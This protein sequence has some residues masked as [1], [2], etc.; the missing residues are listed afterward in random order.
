M[1]ASVFVVRYEVAGIRTQWAIKEFPRQFSF[2]RREELSS[3][4]EPASLSADDAA[5]S[6][7]TTTARVEERKD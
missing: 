1:K 2:L 5:E 6:G 3:S 4:I 7:W